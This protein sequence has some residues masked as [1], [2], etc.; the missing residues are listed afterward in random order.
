MHTGLQ[1]R[2]IPYLIHINKE[3]GWAFMIVCVAKAA[4]S[5]GS[6]FRLVNH[7]AAVPEDFAAPGNHPHDN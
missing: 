1:N 4:Q 6:I 7:A 5:T 3:I 2:S